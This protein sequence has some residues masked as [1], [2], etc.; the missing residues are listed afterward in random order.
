MI[1]TQGQK[2]SLYLT[3]STKM[4]YT[5]KKQGQ[6]LLQFSMVYL[7]RKLSFISDLCIINIFPDNRYNLNLM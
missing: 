5:K 6:Q 7:D 3:Q 2:R 4:P 1:L